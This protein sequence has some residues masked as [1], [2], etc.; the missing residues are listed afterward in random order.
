MPGNVIM[1]LGKVLV[2]PALAAVHQDPIQA[3]QVEEIILV[4]LFD[5][6]PEAVAFYGLRLKKGRRK[7][8]F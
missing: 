5:V 2:H 4:F 7:E 6:P 3:H 8:R 1:A